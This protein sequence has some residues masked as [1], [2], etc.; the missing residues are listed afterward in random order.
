MTLLC[1]V[2]GIVL[3]KE[4]GANARLFLFVVMEII[5]VNP[6]Q[7]TRLLLVAGM[8]DAFALPD[9]YFKMCAFLHFQFMPSLF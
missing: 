4:L 8:E 2:L 6:S 7:G 9:Q 1:Q 3:E 5:S